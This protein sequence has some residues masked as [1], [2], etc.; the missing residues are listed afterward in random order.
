MRASFVVAK[1]SISVLAAIAL[2]MPTLSVG[3]ISL[4]LAVVMTVIFA[5]IELLLRVVIII[6]LLYLIRVNSGANY[7]F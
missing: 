6:K 2:S 4:V 7:R 1:A 3:A 5:I